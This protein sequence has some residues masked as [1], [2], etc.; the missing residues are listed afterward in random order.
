MGLWTQGE[1]GRVGQIERV[2]LIQFTIMS[3]ADSQWE[4]TL[5]HWE[6]SS[7]FCDDLDGWVGGREGSSKGKGYMYT[8]S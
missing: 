2:A 6:A 7:V 5:Q 8:Y 3:K 4:A 1:K